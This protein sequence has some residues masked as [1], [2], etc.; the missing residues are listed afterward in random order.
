MAA[1]G[2]QQFQHICLGF[3]IGMVKANGNCSS[4]STMD[5][6]IVLFFPCDDDVMLVLPLLWLSCDGDVMLM[7]TLLFLSCNEDVAL[8]IMSFLFWTMVFGLCCYEIQF[9]VILIIVGIF[10]RVTWEIHLFINSFFFFNSSLKKV[11]KI[12]SGA[13][14]FFKLVINSSRNALLLLFSQDGRW[15]FISSN[16]SSLKLLFGKNYY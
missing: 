1:I 2:L 11:I 15:L 13:T 14:C 6:T 10:F 5:A 16:T 12:L 4:E 9:S 8:M 7:M 3:M